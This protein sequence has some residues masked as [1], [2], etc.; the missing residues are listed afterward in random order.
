M[1]GLKLLAWIDQ[2]CRQI[3]PEQSAEPFGGLNI[4]IGGDFYQL[5]PVLMRPLYFNRPLKDPM[6]IAGRSLYERFNCTIELN[7]VRRQD[8]QSTEAVA[9]KR[10]LDALR[11]NRVTVENW[12]L[13]ATRVQ[14]V[15][16]S[17]L[18]PFDNALHIYGTKNK[19]RD[20]NQIRL[21]DLQQ[22]IITVHATH[23]GYKADEASTEEAGNLHAI[24]LIAIQSRVMLTE[25]LWVERGLVNGALGTVHN[26]IW[27]PGT[28]W[29]KE[30]PLALLVYFD[31][32]DGPEYI[33]LSTGEKLVPIFR[34]RRDFFRGTEA[35]SRTQFALTTAFAITVHKSQGLTV[36]RAVLNLTDRDFVVGLS[37]VAVSRVKTLAGVLFE[38]PFDFER[39]HPTPSENA[40]MRNA[41]RIRRAR[42]HF[43]PI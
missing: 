15:V 8:G 43:K 30:P 23:E 22:P 31:K 12:A 18:S 17:D 25:N 11:E 14:A 41:D 5:P 26:I 16:S 6:E 13:L 36:D 24:I 38:E 40:R 42:Q 7:I 33:T 29:R 2:R 35:C 39:F 3:F 19:V 21:R 32:Y 27:T 28:D 1:I 4:I 37:Y 34:S 20:F 9:F 10:A